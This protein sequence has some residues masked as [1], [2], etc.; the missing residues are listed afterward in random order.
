[1]KKTYLILSAIAVVVLGVYFTSPSRFF[2]EDVIAQVKGN[3]VIAYD[4]QYDGGTSHIE[5]KQDEGTL[6]FKCTLG[7][8]ESKGAWCG[9]LFDLTRE[10]DK[11]YRDWSFVD[12]VIINLESAGSDEVLLKIW[13]FDPEVTDVKVARSF[14]LLMKEI[15]LS[16]GAQRVSIPL[17]QFYTP[18]FW[19]SDV[20]ADHDPDGRYHETVARLEI[21][22]GWNQPRGKPFALRIMSLQ[23]KG[24]SNFTFGIVLF[25]MLGLFI[26]ALGIKHSGHKKDGER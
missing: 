12:S 10:G 21:A 6:D 1:M 23:A 15:P 22:P 16:G 25:A 2:V 8:D 19:H 18:E 3:S 4:D 11:P 13:T 14:R 5:F 20:K 24:L 26:A 9:L 7:A 17:E